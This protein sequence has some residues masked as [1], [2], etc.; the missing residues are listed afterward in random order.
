M[1]SRGNVEAVTNENTRVQSD[2]TV[3][4]EVV[5]EDDLLRLFTNFLHAEVELDE[6]R[7]SEL[8]TT[9]IYEMLT[10]IAGKADSEVVVERSIRNIDVFQA[11]LI[12]D[13]EARFVARVGIETTVGD[14]YPVVNN[15]LVELTAI[16]E[17]GIFRISNQ[18]RTDF[19]N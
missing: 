10:D 5:T 11:R 8:T 15:Q 7:L 1:E 17:E 14:S 2:E 3:L 13:N 19:L 16:R 4:L 6:E 18:T 12:S 9:E